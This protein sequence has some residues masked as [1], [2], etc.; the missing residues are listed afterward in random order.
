MAVEVVR[1][2]LK[3]ALRDRLVVV[4]D[5]DDM[6]YVQDTHLVNLDDGIEPL[7]LRPVLIRA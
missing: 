7:I 1:L 5:V 3:H 2:H 4:L 6:W